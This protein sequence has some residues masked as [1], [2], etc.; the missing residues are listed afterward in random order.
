MELEEVPHAAPI[1]NLLAPGKFEWNFGYVIFNWIL[2]I[3][4]W[5]SVVKLP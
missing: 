5:A 1:V 2:V 3:D 4:V